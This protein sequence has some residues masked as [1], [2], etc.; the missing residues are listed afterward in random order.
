MQALITVNLV[1]NERSH[2]ALSYK[3][4]WNGFNS[5]F[6]DKNALKRPKSQNY[7]LAAIHDIYIYKYDIIIIS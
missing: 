2:R 1:S 6:D 7:I 3:S 5:L 4:F